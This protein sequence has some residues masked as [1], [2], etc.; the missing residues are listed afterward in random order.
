MERRSFLKTIVCGGIALTVPISFKESKNKLSLKI[1]DKVKLVGGYSQ[2]KIVEYPG[3]KYIM[4]PVIVNRT[5]TKRFNGLE[6]DLFSFDSF[7][8]TERYYFTDISKK[9]KIAEF[10][11]VEK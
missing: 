8:Y 5:K 4:M 6:T 10:V 3:G 11:G 2:N 9:I 1:G 7:R